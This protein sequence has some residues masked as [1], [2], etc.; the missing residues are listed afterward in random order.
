MLSG[1]IASIESGFPTQG[2]R[3]IVEWMEHLVFG[4]LV[5]MLT[6]SIFTGGHT[7]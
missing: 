6:I 7:L 1:R 2:R 5:L 3:M 4:F